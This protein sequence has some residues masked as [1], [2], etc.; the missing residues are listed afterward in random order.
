M[1]AGD[2]S[3]APQREVKD[4]DLA[5]PDQQLRIGLRRDDID[6]IGD[7]IGANAETRLG[8]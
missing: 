3:L 8:W 5:K 6:A 2:T 1:D 7:A 4:R